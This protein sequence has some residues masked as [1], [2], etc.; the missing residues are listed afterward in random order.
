MINFFLQVSDDLQYGWVSHLHCK[1]L[2]KIWVGG[3][4]DSRTN[5]NDTLGNKPPSSI[6]F[7]PFRRLARFFYFFQLKIHAIEN[8]HLICQPPWLYDSHL[9]SI[10]S[11]TTDCPVLVWI[12]RK[13]RSIYPSE[14]CEE[15]NTPLP[16][17]S[18]GVDTACARFGRGFTASKSLVTSEL[19]AFSGY[20][21]IKA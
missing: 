8:R 20:L 5:I 4:C 13:S 3:W 16:C 12:S 10:I 15:L 19:N 17:P 14:E 21:G 7:L 2:G 11:D 1:I 9:Y 6:K 18:P